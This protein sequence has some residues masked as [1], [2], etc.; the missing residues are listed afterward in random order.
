MLPKDFLP[1]KTVYDYFRKWRRD[2]TWEKIHHKFVEWE[3]VAHLRQYQVL[4]PE[5][6]DGLVA[7]AMDKL[8]GARAKYDDKTQGKLDKIIENKA[9]KSRQ[10]FFRKYGRPPEGFDGEF[11]L[12]NEVIDSQRVD[13]CPALDVLTAKEQ[14]RIDKLVALR[15]EVE[16][17]RGLLESVLARYAAA[18]S[19]VS[20]D[21]DS[22]IENMDSEEICGFERVRLPPDLATG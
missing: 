21:G 12:F 5:L 22:D 14:G 13:P 10:L 11:D 8:D 15:T 7:E 18:V 2:K 19:V 20:I 16:I 9:N 17:R 3:R 6:I 4:T 1:C